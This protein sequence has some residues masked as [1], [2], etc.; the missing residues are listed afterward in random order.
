MVRLKE[1]DPNSSD[2]PVKKWRMKGM[3]P[4]KKARDQKRRSRRDE[5]F[6]LPLV[7]DWKEAG[8]LLDRWRFSFVWV[9]C[10]C[11]RFL[12]RF[13]IHSIVISWLSWI[14]KHCWHCLLKRHV[15]CIDVCQ[16]L[17]SVRP[18]SFVRGSRDW[19]PTVM[20]IKKMLTSEQLLPT[21]NLPWLS[22][23]AIQGTWNR[24]HENPNPLD[25]N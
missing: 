22:W 18:E 12:L 19:H 9:M 20:F 25:G 2:D 21:I 17:L 1:G 6:C 13:S 16:L 4:N 10:S 15:Y 24:C 5:Y 8:G 11:F 14:S 7:S 23:I 3:P